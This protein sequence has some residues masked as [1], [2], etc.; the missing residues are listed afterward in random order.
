M[1]KKIIIITSIVLAVALAVGAFFLVKPF[2]ANIGVTMNPE[3]HPILEEIVEM[4]GYTNCKITKLMDYSD[5][6]Y[7]LPKHEE[8]DTTQ[9]IHN[10]GEA[11]QTVLKQLLAGCEFE[12][13]TDE[14]LNYA[15]E[16]VSQYETEAYLY[17]LSLEDYYTQVLELDEDGFYDR[18][19]KESEDYVKT[20]LIMGAIANIE[21][22]E[23]SKEQIIAE[24]DVND[25][26]IYYCY[27]T[28]ENKVYGLF[29][30]DDE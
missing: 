29:I 22:P 1:K 19:Y 18:C 3:L 8:G 4:E 12:M 25:A 27:Q 13:N 30:S 14:V 15:V 28:V 20:Y 10:I 5:I 9:Q 16:L 7:T 17:S 23:L 11:R 26:D 2:V 6:H 21:F 24:A